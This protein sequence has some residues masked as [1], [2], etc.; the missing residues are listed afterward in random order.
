MASNPS[1][2]AIEVVRVGDLPEFARH[3]LGDRERYAVVPITLRR[4]DSQV[5]NPAA[6]ADDAG[7]LVATLGGVCVGYLGLLPA[8]VVDGQDIRSVFCLSTLFVAP[9]YRKTGAGSLLVMKAASLGRDLCVAGVSDDA[10]PVF[11]AM[12]F[13]TSGPLVYLRLRTGAV[14]RPILLRWLIGRLRWHGREIEA[15][16]TTEVESP[17]GVSNAASGGTAPHFLRD[18]A[19]VNWMIRH[20][21]I[22]EGAPPR[23]EYAFSHHR[24]LFRYL[25]FDLREPRT[26]ARLG[27]AVLSVSSDKGRTVLKLLDRVLADSDRSV[28]LL[29]FV[30]REA[31]RWSADVVELPREFAV[32]LRHSWIATACTQRA[33]RRHLAYTRDPNG[34]FGR[35]LPAFLQDVCD[36]D[37]PFV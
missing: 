27:Y 34:P 8:R 5:L 23:H 28:G 3:A 24:D 15:L 11:K 35:R 6:S 26:G 17:P 22:G 10:A 2:L 13:T 4:A 9:P 29:A 1:H 20:P 16:P 31:L 36:G 18:D 37:A 32:P 33:E 7:L 19:V 30:L 21:W 12:R 25:P 14:L